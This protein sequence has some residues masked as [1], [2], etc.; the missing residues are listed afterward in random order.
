MVNNSAIV[1]IIDQ[2]TEVSGEA[3]CKKTLQKMVYLIEEKNIDLGCEYGIHFYGPYSADLDF[4]V[5]ELCDQGVLWIDYTPMDHKI[6]VEDKS[7]LSSDYSNAEM[8]KIIKT[9][10]K[11]SPSDL[12]LLATALY[13]Y[14]KKNDVETIPDGVKK[15]KGSKYNDTRINKAI[16]QLTENGYIIS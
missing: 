12:E 14:G 1:N 8:D 13:V 11:C 7:Q 16:D 10:A 15:I 3:P 4:A 5:R 9:F 6:M 2:I